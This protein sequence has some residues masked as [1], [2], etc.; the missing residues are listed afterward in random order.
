MVVKLGGSLLRDPLPESLLDDIGEVRTHNTLALVH[1]GGD[2]VTEV[3]QRLG[4]E[5]RFITSPGGIR[6]RYTDSETAEIYMMVMSGLIAKRLML[7]LAR[8]GISSLTL[9]GVDAHLFKGMRK[10]KLA[11]LNER[12]RKTIIDGGYTGRIVGVNSD[13]IELL[14]N[15]RYLPIISPIAIS[16]ETEELNVEGDRAAAALATGIRADAVIFLSNVEGLI[17]NGKLIERLTVQDA[18]ARLASIGYGMQRK[19]LAGIEAVEGGVQKAIICSGKKP[20]PIQSA[21]AHQ[22]CT[23]IQ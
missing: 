2:I 10:K 6:S 3:A 19:V 17:L 5:Q 15:N 18:R 21:L 12:G 11:I 7:Q 20:N 8:R 14:M 16:E 1:G 23:V 9:S 4:K 22:G 13:F